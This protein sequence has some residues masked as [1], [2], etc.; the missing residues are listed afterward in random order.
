MAQALTAPLLQLVAPTTGQSLWQLSAAIPPLVAAPVPPLAPPPALVLPPAE[1]P[2]FVLAPTELPA[3]A[4]PALPATLGLV[5][6]EGLEQAATSNAQVIKPP[7][8]PRRENLPMWA[9]VY[10]QAP[11]HAS[12]SAFGAIRARVAI[13]DKLLSLRPGKVGQ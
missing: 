4:L 10:M 12:R 3:F 11:A 5:D 2:A 7:T 9:S 6:C 8:K 1:L 13:T